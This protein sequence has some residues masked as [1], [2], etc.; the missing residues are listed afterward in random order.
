MYPSWA[1]HKK[2]PCGGVVLCWPLFLG[3]FLGWAFF[4]WGDFLTIQ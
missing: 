4:V 3:W 1:I 2:N